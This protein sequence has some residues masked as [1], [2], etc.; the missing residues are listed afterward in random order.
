MGRINPNAGTAQRLNQGQG[1]AANTAQRLNQ[2]QS[3]PRASYTSSAERLSQAERRTSQGTPR[4]SVSSTA[5]R[6]AAGQSTARASNPMAALGAELRSFGN[7]VPR[8]TTVSDVPVEDVVRESQAVPLDDT[9][10][11]PTTDIQET[12]GGWGAT[13]WT[14]T[15]FAGVGA[16]IA[17]AYY[18]FKRRF[19][20]NAKPNRR[21]RRWELVRMVSTAS[22]AFRDHSNYRPSHDSY[23]SPRSTEAGLRPSNDSMGRFSNAGPT[24][25]TLGRNL[26]VQT[27]GCS[28]RPRARP[29]ATLDPS[30]LSRGR[31]FSPRGRSAT[32]ESDGYRASNASY[33]E[34]PRASHE[35]SMWE[36]MSKGGKLS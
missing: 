10:E 16:L 25:P 26:T 33:I 11:L 34:V 6:L 13:M 18:W 35:P 20:G 27:T 14:I 24:R 21:L 15:G 29:R 4:Q 17:G 32:H 31:N 5:E 12:S 22:D 8:N 2:G 36:R 7:N 23:D 19:V 1:A 28:P 9:P 30:E 3:S